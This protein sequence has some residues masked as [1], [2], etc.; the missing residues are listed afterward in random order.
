MA[1]YRKGKP[2]FNTL[3]T[4]VPKDPEIKICLNI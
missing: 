4:A 3:Q 1:V 2:I